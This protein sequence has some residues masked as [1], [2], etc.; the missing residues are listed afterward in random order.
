MFEDLHS[1]IPAPTAAV[2][3]HLSTKEM[4]KRQRGLSEKP[5]LIG[6]VPE[7]PEIR[8]QIH[9]VKAPIAIL[10]VTVYYTSVADLSCVITGPYR[11]QCTNLG[12]RIGVRGN[13]LFLSKES[14]SAD[15]QL[16]QIS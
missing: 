16:D 6:V 3:Y 11:L 15:I 8:Y 14:P 7:D 9:T 2:G 4:Y 1:F 10:Q 13:H 5:K 12:E